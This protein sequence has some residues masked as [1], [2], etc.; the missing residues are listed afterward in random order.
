M[1]WIKNK[2]EG[3]RIKQSMIIV[4]FVKQ[5]NIMPTK[6]VFFLLKISQTDG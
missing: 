4:S 1:K 3:V 5:H 2:K 6:F